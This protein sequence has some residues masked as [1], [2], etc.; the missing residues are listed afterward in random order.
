MMV[1]GT[2]ATTRRDVSIDYLR[3]FVIV[4]V[5]LL[6]S[7]I[8]YTSFS[9]LDQS[10]WVK[11][12][13]PIVD[14]DRFTLFD[15]VV[16][17]MD[18]FLM[19][20]MFLVSGF[21]ILSGLRKYGGGKYLFHRLQRLGIPFLF[22]ALII[23]PL[24][25]LPSFLA[26]HPQPSEPYLLRFFTKDGWPVG[27]PWFLW[28]LLSFNTVLAALYKWKPELLNKFGRMPSVR[29]LFLIPLMA[30]FPL[31]LIATH[32]W[33]VTVGPFDCQPIRI[34]VYFS[35]LLMGAAIGNA[36]GLQKAA[37][38]R[39]WPVWLFIGV[40][41]CIAGGFLD[42]DST[43]P[44]II[45]L[46]SIGFTASGIGNSLGFLGI[47]RGMGDR[48]NVFFDSLSENSFGIYITHYMFTIWIQYF[49]L[50]IT[51]PPILKLTIAFA[52]SL[53]LSW[54]TSVV[55]RKIPLVRR[56]I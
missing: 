52:G 42:G 26:A 28:V 29:L 46:I 37:W 13:A 50:N 19:P 16:G 24:A 5:V 21:Y 56:Y 53:L 47:F 49:L 9:Y 11:S 32:H 31:R 4:L 43:N 3:A 34:G 54:G 48:R 45:L 51:M 36:G 6:H 12:S 20:L 27:P 30:F 44:V 17:W 14:A 8:A 15:P 39:L 41:A 40:T 38:M 18:T 10:N 33:W 35:C 1:K 2:G 22:G 23:A 25:F 55:I 7:A